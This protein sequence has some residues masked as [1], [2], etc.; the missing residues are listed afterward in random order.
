MNVLSI[1]WYKIL[2]AHYGGQKGI[3][4]FNKY[5]AKQTELTCLCS[6]DNI[7][8]GIDYSVL[9]KL[10]V[11][12]K[13]FAD[14]AVWKL[15]TSTAREQKATHIL[16]EH[17]YHGIAAI[18]ACR[19]TGAK[20][21]VHSHNIESQRFRQ[22]GK[23]GWQLLSRYERWVH[24]QA[25]LN[26]FKSK[27]DRDFAIKRFGLEPDKCVIIP[28]GIEKVSNN[29]K[30]KNSGIPDGTEGKSSQSKNPVSSDYEL[31][32]LFAGTL[33]YQPNAAAVEAIYQQI[34]P[35][36]LKQNY[37][38]RITIAGRNRNPAFQY[39]ER[40]QHPLVTRLPE[41]DDIETYFANAD[42][43]INPVLQGGGIQTK[44][45]E[46][47]AH[48]TNV[49]AFDSMIDPELKQYAGEKLFSVKAGHWIEFVQ[50]IQKAATY[51]A[52]T[53]DTFFEHYDWE[54]ITSEL[55]ARIA[56]I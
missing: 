50:Q 22:L 21:I 14:P 5:L 49:V 31:Q 42:V 43:F 26:L 10:P 3:A 7:A 6:R 17:P 12:K 46:A 24:R 11:G 1:V 54:R 34:A 27:I 55:A 35:A 48:H 16:L 23:Q 39:L 56:A 53:P 41:V 45:I 40:L 19:A 25:D 8:A 13:Q 44:N 9:P 2:P 51:T 37:P 15:I 29:G 52:N 28:Y 36:L 47:L 30:I 18:R 20:L 33:D 32:V 4:L 38:C